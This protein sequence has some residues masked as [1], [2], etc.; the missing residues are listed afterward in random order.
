M[1]QD[2]GPERGGGAGARRGRRPWQRERG[3]RQVLMIIM[4]ILPLDLL[5]SDL[6]PRRGAGGPPGAA[7]SADSKPEP[8]WL[9][10]RVGQPLQSL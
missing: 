7:E 9:R 3:Q 10:L 4:I 5:G 6:A 8:Q 2:P 1:A